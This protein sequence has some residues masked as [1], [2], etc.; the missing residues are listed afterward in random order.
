MYPWEAKDALDDGPEAKPRHQ[1]G[2]IEQHVAQR[3]VM[4]EEDG[5][6]RQQKHQVNCSNLYT[7]YF[8]SSADSYFGYILTLWPFCSGGIV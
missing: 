3:A 2:P 1:E 4:A 6:D 8:A 7:H 5:K